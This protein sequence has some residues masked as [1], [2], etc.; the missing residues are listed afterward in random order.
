[1]V[2]LYLIM[3]MGGLFLCELLKDFIRDEKNPMATRVWV[4]RHYGTSG[5]AIYSLFEVTLAGCWPNYFRP[6][7]FEVSGYFVIF[8]MV[9]ISLVVF[10]IIRIITAIFLKQTLQIAGDDDEMMINEQ[11]KRKH[12][13]MNKLNNI[14][15]MV[16]TQGKGTLSLDE[17]QTVMADSKVRSWL[18]V[19]EI[20]VHDASS[21]FHLLDDGD[22]EVTY[23]EFLKGVMRLKGQARSIDVVAIMHSSDQTLMMV[24]E[25]QAELNDVHMAIGG[26]ALGGRRNSRASNGISER[27]RSLISK[28][29]G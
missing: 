15:Q 23:D 17:F 27:R 22:G 13:Y 9:Y 12:T 2:L 18:Q 6:L 20:E 16:D 4:Y 8:S 19:L 11:A 26:G 14:F 28:A 21:L 10:A 7:I 5:R 29:N 1:M 25:M 3:I 24:K